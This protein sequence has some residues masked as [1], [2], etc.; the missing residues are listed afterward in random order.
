VR[1]KED[2]TSVGLDLGVMRCYRFAFELHLFKRFNCFPS[3][4]IFEWFIVLARMAKGEEEESWVVRELGTWMGI[5]IAF[6]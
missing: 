6:A 4:S 3:D 1:A 5:V 2:F